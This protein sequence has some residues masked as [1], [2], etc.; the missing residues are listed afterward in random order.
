MHGR[1]AAK[2]ATSALL[3]TTAEIRRAA[4]ASAESAAAAKEAATAASAAHRRDAI[5]DVRVRTER[6]AAKPNRNQLR[7]ILLACARQSTTNPNS[8]S[9]ATQNRMNWP[10]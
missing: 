6:A 4:T 9:L 1:T 10:K 8:F 2:S 3:G 5:R 7:C